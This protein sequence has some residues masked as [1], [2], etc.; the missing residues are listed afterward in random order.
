MSNENDPYWDELGIP[1]RTDGGY[2]TDLADRLRVRIHRERRRHLLELIGIAL[3]AIFG[4]IAGVLWIVD[5]A[6][7][8][9]WIGIATVVGVLAAGAL[10]VWVRSQGPSGDT[11]TLLGMI[12]LSIAHARRQQR[13]SKAAYAACVILLLV[14]GL[15]AYLGCS[16]LGFSR[17]ESMQI[18]AVTAFIVVITLVRASRHARES[19]E[20]QRRFEYAKHSLSS[21]TAVQ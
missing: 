10:Y 12:D 14:A 20:T 8:A 11:Q 19:R 6:L 7:S 5:P 21:M 3:S 4:I 13:D 2:T 15:L 16:K 1:W 9:K 17:L 18:V